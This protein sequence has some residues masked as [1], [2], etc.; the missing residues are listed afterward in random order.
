MYPGGC[1]TLFA[2]SVRYK[3]PWST[4]SGFISHDAF[5]QHRAKILT[6]S[7][8]GLF[9]QS[10]GFLETKFRI[11]W[12]P[13]SLR[14]ISVIPWFLVRASGIFEHRTVL[15]IWRTRWLEL[16]QQQKQCDQWNIYLIGNCVRPK[17][18]HHW[19]EITKIFWMR[20]TWTPNQKHIPQK[21]ALK[22]KCQKE[23]GKE[24]RRWTNRDMNKFHWAA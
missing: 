21:T 23:P 12:A 18:I 7:F 24:K 22:G 5:S 8:C 2:D 6:L 10:W 1:K 11:S 4:S 19:S 15:L 14:G 20:K 3:T 17:K 13:V 9:E 16:R